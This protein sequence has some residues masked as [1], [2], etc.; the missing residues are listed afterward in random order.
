MRSSIDYRPSAESILQLCA[1]LWDETIDNVWLTVQPFRTPVG[2][3]LW[4]A[5]VQP[6]IGILPHDTAPCFV[7]ESGTE[8]LA[9]VQLYE[10]VAAAFRE[11]SEGK[12]IQESG[13]VGFPSDDGRR[14]WVAWDRRTELYRVVFEVTEDRALVEACECFGY[15]IVDF[16]RWQCSPRDLV[17]LKRAPM[18]DR[19]QEE[20]V[21]SEGVEGKAIA[22]LARIEAA[23]HR[24]I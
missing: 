13:A 5:I 22:A 21:T 2:N 10:Q 12:A 16:A 1:D 23:C 9:M 6:I 3:L 7:V 20:Q 11:T 17:R 4:R 8:L 14:A 18:L 19:Y 15:D 24:P